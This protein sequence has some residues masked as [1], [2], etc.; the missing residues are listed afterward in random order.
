M[1][2]YCCAHE[3]SIYRGQWWL[4]TKL[5]FMH[6]NTELSFFPSSWVGVFSNRDG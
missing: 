3:Y 6:L 5:R 2:T 1:Y 4:G